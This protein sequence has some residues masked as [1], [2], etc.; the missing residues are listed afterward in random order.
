MDTF[1]GYLTLGLG[2]LVALIG[3]IYNHIAGRIN[4]LE[5]W[6]EDQPKVTE[7]I[8]FARHSTICQAQNHELKEFIKEENKK[9]LAYFDLKM[10]N[11]IMRELRKNQ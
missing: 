7:I 8:T 5:V 6:K 4:K 1:I 2:I 3:V 10:E 11:E 9:I